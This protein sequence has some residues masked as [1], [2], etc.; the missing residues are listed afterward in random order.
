MMLLAGIGIGCMLFFTICVAAIQLHEIG[1]CR[2][3]KSSNPTLI[4]RGA[5]C[6]RGDVPFGLFFDGETIRF[7]MNLP[8]DIEAELRSRDKGYTRLPNDA[9]VQPLVM[10]LS[11]EAATRGVPVPD[12]WV[13]EFTAPEDGAGAPR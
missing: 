5:K 9:I 10:M 1:E 13:D 4:R 6:L 8:P 11:S 3:A 7:N 12:I 2:R